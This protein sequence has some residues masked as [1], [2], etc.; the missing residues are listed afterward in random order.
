MLDDYALS[1]LLAAC[2]EADEDDHTPWLILADLFEE[3]SD[4]RS[5]LVR[6]GRRG[7]FSTEGDRESARLWLSEHRRL[8]LATDLDVP[9]TLSRACLKVHLG[10]RS[11]QRLTASPVPGWPTRVV[12]DLNSQEDI[13]ALPGRLG[14]WRDIPWV[15]FS[16]HLTGLTPTPG[17]LKALRGLPRLDLLGLAV[18]ATN[19]SVANP[20]LL[21]AVSRV[22]LGGPVSKRALEAFAQIPGLR[23]LHLRDVSRFAAPE[24]WPDLSPL[25]TLRHL[26]LTA[27]IVPDGT[28]A[29][30]ARDFPLRALAARPAYG[31][32]PEP[33]LPAVTQAFVG[34]LPN[35]REL[36]QVELS[37][38]TATEELLLLG[39]LPELERLELYRLHARPAGRGVMD[40]LARL[41]RLR[42]IGLQDSPLLTDEHLEPLAGAPALEEID[43]RD[44]PQV[45]DA[46]LEM[47]A[48]VPTLRLVQARRSRGMDAATGNRFR[49]RRPDC[50]LTLD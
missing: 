44:C 42:R 32:E 6:V 24:G 38:L 18:N 19:Q 5:R 36:R 26:E 16:V 40:A 21:P 11:L 12:L 4:P 31:A 9:T 7:A 14:A 46:T 8:L 1:G 2:C 35:W 37:H 22:T 13:E 23:E 47:L 17:V 49:K 34:F 43:V 28:I 48:G 25:T 15:R 10:S 27:G 20:R 39:D 3:R 45:T 29:E 30:W 41:P 50:V 33:G